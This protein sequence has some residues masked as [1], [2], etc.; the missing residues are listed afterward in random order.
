MEIPE[1]LAYKIRQFRNSG[2]V[3]RYGG[4]LFATPNWLAVFLGQEIWPQHYDPLVDQRP[5]E[6]VRDNLRQIR[7]MIRQAAEMAPRHEE[8]I[9]RH[10]GAA[11]EEGSPCPITVFEAS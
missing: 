4:D 3:V 5:T 9:E 7:T 11:G 1:A 6:Q 10:C 8:Y 2:R